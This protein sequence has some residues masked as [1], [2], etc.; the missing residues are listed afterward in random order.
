[1]LFVVQDAVH[2]ASMIE[3][4]T[5]DNEP[6]GQN[7]QIDVNVQCE[8]ASS[9]VNVGGVVPQPIVA[10][11]GL[12]PFQ[13]AMAEQ[14][15]DTA[16]VLVSQAVN[17]CRTLFKGGILKVGIKIKGWEMPGGWKAFCQSSMPQIMSQPAAS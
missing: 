2:Q 8:T 13:N 6:L 10:P 15:L 16:P 5:I 3:A 1:M 9:V 7:I 4:L 17:Q 12:N 11:T 14:T